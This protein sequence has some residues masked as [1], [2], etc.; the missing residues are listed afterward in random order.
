[1]FLYFSPISKGSPDSL[2]F[3]LREHKWDPYWSPNISFT[4]ISSSYL[5]IYSDSGAS[6]GSGWCFRVVNREWLNSKYVRW[7]WNASVPAS[8]Q[9]VYV[10]IF[11][12]S[13]DRTNNTDFPSGAWIAI[14][15]KGMLQTLYGFDGPGSFTWETRDIQVNVASGN[16][17]DCT[18]FF[19][20]YDG[21]NPTECYLN[22]DWFEINGAS[23]GG[24][25]LYDEQFSSS[26]V[27][28]QTGTTGDYGYIST[29]D[30]NVSPS[31]GNFQAPSTVYAN[32]YFL[33][34]ATGNDADGKTTIVNMTLNL[35]GSIILKWDNAT[36]TFSEYSDPNDYCTLDA[37]NSVRTS[38]NDTAWKISWKI[39]LY[40]NFSEG[41]I[42]VL[43]TE[44]KIF[45]DQGASGTGTTTS[46]FTFEDDL[47]IHTDATV[48]DDHVDPLQSVTFTA[49]IYYQGTS[50]AP[51][52]VTGIIGRVELA[53]VLKGS[54]TDVTGGLSITINAETNVLQ[55]GYNIYCVTDENSVTNQTVNVIVDKVQVTISANTTNPDAGETVNFTVTAVYA[56]N[57]TSVSSWTVN[58][59]RNA[60]HFASGN[61]TD[62][63]SGEIRYEYTAE[64]VTEATYGLSNF[65]SNTV[66]VIWANLFIK[67]DQ[68][69]V[70]DSNINVETESTSYYHCRFASN[71]TDCPS[72]TLY[73]NGT[74][75]SIN[76]TGWATV[77]FTFGTVDMRVFATTGINV[78]GETD[79]VQIPANPEIVWNRA[80]IVSG[81]F[82]SDYLHVGTSTTL[83]FVVQY[84]YELTNVVD[85]SVLANST[86]MTYNVTS[87]RW[88]YTFTQATLGNYSYVI[89][90]VTGNAYG[91]TTINDVAGL[92]NCTFYANLYLRTVDTED[93]VIADT[94]VVYMSNGTIT[95]GEPPPSGS[96]GI[97]VVGTAGDY[98]Y[99]TVSNGWANWTGITTTTIQV[100]VKWHG[101]IVNSTFTIT[102]TADKTV[103]VTCLCYPFTLSGTLYHV[104]SNATISSTTFA[105]YVLTVYFSSG[106]STY[107]MCA[108]GPRPTFLLNVTYDLAVDYTTYL[109]IS[110]YSNATISVAYPNWGDTYI[111]KTDQRMTAIAWLG[112]KLTLTFTGTATEIGTVE[113]Y[114]GSRGNPSDRGGFTVTSYTAPVFIGIYA[115]A[116]QATVWV[117]WETAPS[118]PSGPSGPAVQVADL[119]VIVD[120]TI[121]EAYAGTTVN[122]TLHVSWRGD[123]IAYQM[124]YLYDVKFDAPYA[125]WTVKLGCYP[126]ILEKDRAQVQGE[127]YVNVTIYIPAGTVG[128]HRIPFTA[129]FGTKDAG[130]R[131]AGNVAELA[132]TTY[133]PSPISNIMVYLFL[134]ILGAVI[135]GSIF[136]KKRKAS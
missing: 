14:K 100:Y 122:G 99:A 27:M 133:Q 126:L 120:L 82:T 4:T 46:L 75:F 129:T 105:S 106:E 116:S 91:I 113:I 25:P 57:G 15:G 125:N 30:F 104:A 98:F 67:I 134:G 43:S 56:Y 117:S 108:S 20:L 59:F 50:T 17:S 69:T 118:G 68:I 28:E 21:D 47:I 8:A 88:E 45:D 65:T 93:N 109:Q 64:N 51:E 53:G 40:W 84:E 41:S 130:F 49:T 62:Y 101:L 9:V 38:V 72:G 132:I 78:D 54:D 3:Q 11:D 7:R 85:G 70:V 128:Q 12:G 16:Q 74:G 39:K 112:Y 18:I 52:D 80:K 121:P 42:F 24:N 13:Y 83:Y 94:A 89:T 1:M 66:T 95:G 34:N 63:S 33:I 55:Y 103:N 26:V 87:Q 2:Q 131:I 115:F 31:I 90:S 6:V 111:R 48:N 23:N 60:T 5:Q 22:I 73:V 114:C 61:F 124:I 96:T 135:A 19:L 77:N 81:G 97:A 107:V 119:Y 35:N 110:H 29:G 127:V 102:M 36:D 44:T 76:S 58:I 86:A 79:Y 10:Q 71:Q 136:R 123:P 32:Q 37:P 92:Q